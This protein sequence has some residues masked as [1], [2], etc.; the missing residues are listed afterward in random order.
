M[1]ANKKVSLIIISAV[2]AI[3]IGAAS[4]AIMKGI[5]QTNPTAGSNNRV[6][7]IND[8]QSDPLAFS[9]EVTINGVVSGFSPTD[10]T[11]FGV[12]DT[13]ELLLCGDFECGAFTLFTEYVGDATIPALGDEVNITG[14][15]VNLGNATIFRA[16]SVDINRNVMDL[17]SQ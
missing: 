11:A 15:F 2:I 17:I 4:L 3:I 14:T 16:T 6:L 12:M 7:T 5:N 9:G 10:K 8:I 1:S 13:E